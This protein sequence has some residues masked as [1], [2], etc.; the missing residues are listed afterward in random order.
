VQALTQLVLTLTEKR[1]GPQLERGFLRVLLSPALRRSRFGL[2]SKCHR[3]NASSREQLGSTACL[4]GAHR[5]N[6]CPILF[7]SYDADEPGHAGPAVPDGRAGVKNLGFTG[8]V[9]VGRLSAEDLPCFT[10]SLPESIKANRQIVEKLYG[11]LHELRLDACMTEF[12]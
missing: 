8:K 7:P 5:A 2:Q 11:E 4:R 6:D 9:Y 1:G 12:G 10:Q 3:A